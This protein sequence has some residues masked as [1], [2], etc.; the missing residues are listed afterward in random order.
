MKLVLLAISLLIAA[1]ASAKNFWIP[2]EKFEEHNNVALEGSPV[3]DDVTGKQVYLLR[4]GEQVRIKIGI[5]ND[6]AQY[7]KGQPNFHVCSLVANY[8]TGVTNTVLSKHPNPGNTKQ[9]TLSSDGYKVLCS[10]QGKIDE[11]NVLTSGLKVISPSQGLVKIRGVSVRRISGTRAGG[12]DALANTQAG[13]GDALANYEYS[14]AL[15]YLWGDGGSTY[16]DSFLYYPKRNTDTSNHFGSVA[17]AYFGSRLTKN[18]QGTRYLLRLSGTTPASFL[19]R[20]LPL[21][22]IPDKHAFLTSVVET[23]GAVLVA[24]IAD[25]PSL[26]R[27][28]FIRNLVNDLNPQCS[29]STCTDGKCATP[30]CAFIANGKFRGKPYVPGGKANCAV[31][32]SGNDSNWRSMFR[33][34]DFHFVKT[35]RTPGGEPKKYSSTSRPNYT[36]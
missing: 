27:C 25:D 16:D 34:N 29:A 7:L 23:E 4:A 32:L 28:T 6:L 9:H 13:G 2:A 14:R 11:N 35:D 19:E 36:R 30:D 21:S 22:A 17:G 33:S 31:Y 20:G 26:N 15:G 24:R 5:D 3:V 8:D 18:P 10:E 1:P 12:G